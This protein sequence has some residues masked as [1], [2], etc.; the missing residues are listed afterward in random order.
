[1]MLFTSLLLG[2]LAIARAEEPN[3][4]LPA[5]DLA[6]EADLQ[7]ELALQL[8][9]R[10]DYAGAL[11]HLLHSNRLAP[12][13][14]VL[15]NIARTYERLGRLESAYKYY[16]DYYEA[17]T[18]PELRASAARAMQDLSPKLALVRVDTNPPGAAVFVERRE[19][20]ERGRTPRLLALP[21]GSTTILVE[22]D[23][24]RPDEVQVDLVRGRTAHIDLSLAPRTGVLRVTDGI[25][26]TEVFFENGAFVGVVPI[27]TLLP[28]G[29]H[30]LVFR[31]PGHQSRNIPIDMAPDGEV[32]LTAELAVVK[33]KVIVDALEQGARIE[34]DGV[35]AGFTPAALDVPEGRHTVRIVLRGFAPFETEI[36]VRGD[37]VTEVYT[38]LR[39]V[40]EVRAASR[41]SET[42]DEA[43][44]SV[45]VISQEEI[46]A[47]GYQSVYEA[48]SATRGLTP[49]NDLY[50]PTFG[51]RGY[52]RPGDYGNRMLVTLD[53]H[54]MNDDQLGASFVDNDLTSDLGDIAQIEVVRGPGSALYGTNAFLGVINL[55]PKTGEDRPGPHATIT[56]TSARTVR[57]RVGAGFGDHDT[58]GWLSLSGSTAA[59]EDV[60]LP[61]AT[62]SPDGIIRDADGAQSVTSAARFWHRDLTIHGA[63]HT[64][65]KRVPTG[66]FGTLPGDP[67]TVSDD[68]RGF[69]EVR[70]EPKLGDRT[71]LLARTWID[72]TGFR[73]G[74][75]Y[76][77]GVL[78]DT[79]NGVWIGAEPRVRTS[80]T[81]WLDVTIGTEG[82]TNVLAQLRSV[83]DGEVV[84]DEQPRQTVVSGYA[85]VDARSRW[86][87]GSVGGRYDYFTLGGFGG[88]FNPRA[89][90]VVT[91]T[92]QDVFKLVSGTSFRA[93]SPYELFYNDGGVTQIAPIA[94]ELRPERIFTSEL[95]YTRRLGDVVSLSTSV[96]YNELNQIVELIEDDEDPEIFVFANRDTKVRAIGGE[97]ELRR[98]WRQGW[99]IAL[100]QTWQIAREGDLLRGTPI[101]NVPLQRAALKLAAPIV[102]SAITGSTRLIV[103][104]PRMGWDD[105]WSPWE[106]LWD[107]TLTGDVP[108]LPASWGLGFRNLLDQRILHPTGIDVPDPFVP[109]PRRSL[110]L[111]LRA[112]L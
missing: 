70:Y 67:N 64:R 3:A 51:V 100:H 2:M 106:I 71:Q 7:F 28:A 49:T 59:G 43:P 17:E 53:G 26:G 46:R 81:S 13:R 41:A 77:E 109:Q 104:S 74:Y 54:T 66:A 108:G 75:A 25:P 107:F 23:G 111:T 14:N 80:P 29:R 101:T 95:E 56:A 22:R 19:L 85:V 62:G 110:F 21:P 45:S 94:G 34:I 31:A 60:L 69:G 12:N 93:P 1:M 72:G 63:F 9:R 91:P 55:V 97:W 82:K 48:L 11:A 42:V 18:D 96:W 112:E 39:S 65:R 40:Q 102:P 61:V 98:D 92:D 16:A 87:R 73:G 6:D 103:G 15:F 47:F 4:E 5:P 78:R 89:S 20:G 105:T 90:L 37:E 52:G 38:R 32:N 50:Y 24:Y 76:E 83:D 68:L 8:Y 86:V 33:G 58:G 57:A 88:A 27:D 84:L 79:W 10:G 30:T 99:M 35:A 36:D 44:A